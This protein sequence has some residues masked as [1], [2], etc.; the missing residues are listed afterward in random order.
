MSSADRPSRTPPAA[1]VHEHAANATPPVQSAPAAQPARNSAARRKWPWV[2]GLILLA[3]AAAIGIPWLRDVLTTVS[4]DDAYV[5]G[6]VTF[7]APRVSGQVK[8]VLVDDNN[9]VRKGDLLVELDPEP[10]QVQVDIARAT[11]TAA[12]ADLVA[13]QASVRGTEGLTRSLRYGLERAI[14]DVDD[15][16]ATLKLRVATLQSKKASLT[17]AQA[18]YNR[19]KPLAATGT[20]TQQDMDAYTEAMLVAQAQVQESL[21]AVYEIRVAL[22]LPPQPEKGE[23][24]TQI[25]ADLNQNFS[26]VREAQ[27][28]LIQAAS[29]L[30]VTNAGTGCA[31]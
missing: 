25:P 19:N 24:L 8:Q 29:A 2:V 7:V 23:D 17:K 21:Q 14:E 4:T 11:V 5:N 1:A 15:K 12:T 20:V 30:G 3:G 26:S 22:G 27:A 31:W 9:A 16:V 10:F 6:H 13:A 18:D 28:K